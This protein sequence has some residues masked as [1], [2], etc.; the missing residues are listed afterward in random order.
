[1]N[2]NSNHC[3]FT[4][5]TRGASLL[6]E[7]KSGIKNGKTNPWKGAGII[8][9]GSKRKGAGVIRNGSKRKGIGIIRNG[10]ERKAAFG[11]SKPMDSEHSRS[12]IIELALLG[13]CTAA[14]MLLFIFKIIGG[15]TTAA[16][17]IATMRELHNSDSSYEEQGET[18]EVP[19]RLKLV[20]LPSIIEVFSPSNSPI[21]PLAFERA[22]E[23]EATYIAKLYA[24]S[25]TDVV[26]MLPGTVKTVSTDED[27]GGYVVVQSADDTEICYYG[28]K[29]ISVEPG[30][31]VLQ[32]STLGKVAND[33]LCLR[34]LKQGRPIDPLNFLGVAADIF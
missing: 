33:I 20:Q 8:R 1:M 15:E 28:L 12:S 22:I 10:S 32:H 14:F 6:H 16:D 5:K 31:P 3:N 7:E 24:A 26:S 18:E 34:V 21:K 30:Q 13:G 29:D 19:G 11:K 17:V 27:L 25:G 2:T 4:T 23:D 9:K